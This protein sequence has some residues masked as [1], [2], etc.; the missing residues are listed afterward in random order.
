[1]LSRDPV[2]AA[3]VFGLKPPTLV[4]AELVTK[5]IRTRSDVVEAFHRLIETKFRS[6]EHWW[7]S[8]RALQQV[9]KSL[10]SLN[11][12]MR[13]ANEIYEMA[14]YLPLDQELSDSDLQRM[15]QAM[16]KCTLTGILQ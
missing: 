7:T 8:R 15:R 6:F 14:R 9:D 2:V 10:P 16:E 5:E 11:S 4:S 13:E 12:P 1:M 3:K